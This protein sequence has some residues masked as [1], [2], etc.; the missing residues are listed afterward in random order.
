MKVFV[1]VAVVLLACGCQAE[2]QAVNEEA[3]AYFTSSFDEKMSIMKVKL[4]IVFNEQWGCFET[5]AKSMIS[6]VQSLSFVVPLF[7]GLQSVLNAL[8]ISVGN[9]LTVVVKA[10]NSILDVIL[11][12]LYS[13]IL[14][15]LEQLFSAILGCSNPLS[16]IIECIENFLIILESSIDN[17]CDGVVKLLKSSNYVLAAEALEQ[18]FNNN[19]VILLTQ[20]QNCKTPLSF[21]PFVSLFYSLKMIIL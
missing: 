11:N 10:L 15:A 5:Y 12:S 13:L 16:E 8:F 9:I 18:K 14:P 4:N 20:I 21:V 1:V 2:G 7:G 3:L 6:S 17:L 19:T